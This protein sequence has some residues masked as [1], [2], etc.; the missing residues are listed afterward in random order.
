MKIRIKSKNPELIQELD[1]DEISYLD[2][3][4]NIPISEMPFSNIFGDKYRIIKSFGTLKEDSPFGKI[5]NTLNYF[6]W[7]LAPREKGDKG[8]I[9]LT[10]KYNETKI[11]FNEDN[12]TKL[13]RP[14]KVVQ[15]SLVKWAAGAHNFLTRSLPSMYAK[16][17]QLEAQQRQATDNL[18]MEIEARK[19]ALA[20]MT[21]RFYKP[22]RYMEAKITSNVMKWFNSSQ[23]NTDARYLVP[24]TEADEDDI[25]IG[26][27]NGNDRVYNMILERI[28]EI[29]QFT[30]DDKAMY[31]IQDGFDE[32]FQSTYMIYS[33]HPIDVFRM[34]D[35][36]QITSCHTPKSRRR[37]TNFPEIWDQYNICALAEAY[38]NG[39]VVYSVPLS[40]FEKAEITPTQEGIDEYEDGEI[41]ADDTRGTDGLEPTARLRI[42]NTVA[43]DPET[44]DT[45]SLAV[46]DQI[47]YGTA[48]S[49]FKTSVLNTVA[50]LQQQEIQKIFDNPRMALKGEITQQLGLSD[51]TDGRTFIP[52]KNFERF[53]GSYEDGSAT[54]RNN[55]P[56]ML[57]SALGIKN[58]E[59]DLVGNLAYDESA[60]DELKEILPMGQSL[61]SLEDVL[62]NAINNLNSQGRYTISADLDQDYDDNFFYRDINLELY[63]PLPEYMTDITEEDTRG[64]NDFF[65]YHDEEFTLY[66]NEEDIPPSDI[67][68]FSKNE[69]VAK[70]LG[71]EVPFLKIKYNGL[72]SHMGQAGMFMDVNEPEEVLRTIVD[73]PID[74]GFGARILT[75][76]YVEDAFPQKVA[77]LLSVSDYG[78]DPEF[79]L[80]KILNNHL[81][82]DGSIGAWEE[83][84]LELDFHS[85]GVEWYES[86]KFRS[87]MY[88]E[89]ADLIAMGMTPEQVAAFAVALNTN[90]QV[91]QMVTRLINK[92]LEPDINP[93]L[94]PIS[95]IDNAA[96]YGWSDI[97]DLSMEDIVSGIKEDP[98]DSIIY[99]LEINIDSNNID[100]AQQAKLLESIL[101]EW[102]STFGLSG[103]LDTSDGEA[104]LRQVI[105]ATS[106]PVTERKRRTRVRIIRG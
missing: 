78:R 61:D 54:V 68:V 66:F 20:G 37:E 79:Y 69:Q 82:S 103:A 71:F 47:V 53:G 84:D 67:E 2:E 41:F 75:D 23:F 26:W 32:E 10:K 91:Q 12:S 29:K 96:S 39:M 35:F 83:E 59:I 64:V 13:S 30:D 73:D 40:S 36:T 77:A 50:A 98:S 56:L 105:Q 49:E 24:P 88:L 80:T 106:Q 87:E 8:K 14:E 63:V 27:E 52:L 100:T 104:F 60:Q 4:M 62:N 43:T 6:G 48:K 45:T 86:A 99:T 95:V 81:N 42:R 72:E 21:D 58:S 11:T 1:E 51:G 90:A 7:E 102:D 18:P 28:Q 55:L 70:M 31:K 44:G 74:G 38:A 5:V 57:V 85:S 92:N 15:T 46:P 101:T 94:V 17:K 16:S 22:R 9:M 93:D 25:K 19:A 97:K 76:P 33:R 89:P 3:A 34:S 65:S